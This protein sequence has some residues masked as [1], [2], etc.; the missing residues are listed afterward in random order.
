MYNGE[1]KDTARRTGGRT[2]YYVVV[3]VFG[4]RPRNH[5]E[6]N[7]LRP[8]LEAALV[9]RASVGSNDTE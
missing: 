8:W 1:T 4:E 3:R 6:G 2:A 7:L 9:E 5:F